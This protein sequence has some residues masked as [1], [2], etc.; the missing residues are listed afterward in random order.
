[1]KSFTSLWSRYALGITLLFIL[2][3]CYA[4]AMPPTVAGTPRPFSCASFTESFWEEF[5]FG[6]DSPD[7]IVATVTRLWNIGNDQIRIE[8]VPVR[9][10]RIEWRADFNDGS[11]AIYIASFHEERKLMN[12]RVR[13]GNRQPTLA[14]AIDC[15]GPPQHH[16]AA[17][18]P[19][20]LPRLDLD[21]WYVEKGLVVSSYSFRRRTQLPAIQP[22]YRMN[23]FTVVAPGNLEQMVSNKHIPSAHAYIL[24]RLRPW[25]GSIEAIEVE[26]FLENP[27]C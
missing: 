18:V 3:G 24:C 22:E 5:R 17:F 1:M 7:D 15:L 21:L 6:V 2:T 4:G 9:V 19:D 14:Q 23:Y 16:V 12:I 26:S 10:V 8:P 25:P 20:N 27:R 11:D 13:W